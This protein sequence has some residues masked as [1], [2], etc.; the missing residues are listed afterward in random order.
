LGS[1]LSCDDVDPTEDLESL[2][3]VKDSLE[4]DATIE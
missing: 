4:F 1:L 3:L 2:G